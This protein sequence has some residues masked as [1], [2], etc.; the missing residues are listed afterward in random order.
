MGAE[1]PGAVLIAEDDKR[2]APFV[3]EQKLV[4]ES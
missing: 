4:E 2:E 3:H 1:Y